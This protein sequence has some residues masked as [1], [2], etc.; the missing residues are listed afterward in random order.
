MM[1]AQGFLNSSTP[2]GRTRLRRPIALN[3]SNSALSSSPVVAGEP[4]RARMYC[5]PGDPLGVLP[6]TPVVTDAATAHEE[7]RPQT[8]PNDN[9]GLPWANPNIPGEPKAVT[10]GRFRDAVRARDARLSFVAVEADAGPA[11]HATTRRRP[12]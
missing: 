5:T 11:V 6:L 1:F 10:A 7:L 3:E 8:N 9:S 4:T 12:T 2:E